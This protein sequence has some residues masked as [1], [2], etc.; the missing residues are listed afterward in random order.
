MSDDTERDLPSQVSDGKPGFFDRFAD[1]VSRYTAKA[2]FFASCCLLV[3]VWAPSFL[4]VPDV[5]TWQLLINTP[6]TV[7]T[8]L[9][10][11][12]MQNSSA[13]STAA[14]NQKLNALAK[15]HLA[16]ASRDSQPDA[17]AVA[18]ASQELREVFGLEDR[19]GS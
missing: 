8:F 5:D 2:W 7:V 12:L 9:L 15:F 14:T 10:V 18:T 16:T 1:A 13:R 11:G 3:L 19:E 6:T 4:V 17:P